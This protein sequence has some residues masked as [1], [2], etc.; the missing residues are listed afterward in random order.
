[1]RLEVRSRKP[2]RAGL[3]DSIERRLRFIL[4]R[5][6]SRVQSATVRLSECRDAQGH[7]MKRCEIVRMGFGRIAR[8]EDTGDDF[9]AAMDCATERI[10]RSV[11]RALERSQG[12]TSNGASGT[13]GTRERLEKA[14]DHLGSCR[15][16][17]VRPITMR[18]EYQL[19][20]GETILY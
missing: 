8:I 3:R 20:Y 4:G 10:A 15:G 18:S 5:F 13:A 16:C 14:M 9:R 17:A 6:G 11:Q 19:P 1:M 7:A 12:H 2:V